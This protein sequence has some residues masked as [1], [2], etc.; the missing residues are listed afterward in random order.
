MVL[1]VRS[2]RLYVSDL[3]AYFIVNEDMETLYGYLRD[4][5][6]DRLISPLGRDGAEAAYLPG[7]CDPIR[8]SFFLGV[9]YPLEKRLNALAAR[10]SGNAPHLI[11]GLVI[12]REPCKD[13][14]GLFARPISDLSDP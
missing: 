7:P 1:F 5:N 11:P 12:D 8:V 14:F 4:R 6:V 9:L 2:S 13:P 3:D 10:G